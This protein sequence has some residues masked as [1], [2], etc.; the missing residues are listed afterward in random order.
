[1][2]SARPAFVRPG[3]RVKVLLVAAALAVLL[4]LFMGL[5][6]LS[7]P[8]FALGAALLAYIVM[9]GMRVWS[10]PKPPV[11]ES[12]EPN[13]VRDEDRGAQSPR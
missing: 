3:S 13:R 7:I 5:A 10:D 2:S 1:M 8:V 6:I 12:V 9:E 11:V 4:G